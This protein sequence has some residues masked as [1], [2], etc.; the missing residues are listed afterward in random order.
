MKILGFEIPWPKK[1]A[2]PGPLLSSPSTS[3]GNHGWYPLIRES[4]TGAWQR[5]VTIERANVFQDSTI[6]RCVTLIASDV[7]KLRLKLVA[8]G[9]DGLWTETTNSAYSPLLR[10]PNGFQTRQQFIES[11]ICSKLTAG[12]FYALK[13]RDNRG[14]VTKLYPLDPHRVKPLVSDD[15][16]VFY[17]LKA[18]NI[19]GVD[20]VVIP[21][22]EIIHDRFNCL[23]HPL[24]G[25]SP[26]HAAG[27][28]ATAAQAIRG[29]SAAFFA[30]QSTPSGLLIAPGAISDETAQRLKDGW[31]ANFSGPSGMGK[32]A[33]LGDDLKYQQLAM[34][35]DA[36]QLVEQAQM[37]KEDIATAFGVPLHKIGGPL[38]NVGNIEVLEQAYYSQTIQVIIEGLESCLDEGLSLPS[39]LGVELDLDGLLRMDT[40]AQ[41][42]AL[43]DAVGAGFMS[44]NEARR[45]IELPAIKGGETPYLQQQ[46]YSLE[47]LAKRDAQADPFNPS[48]PSA[49]DPAKR[50][51]TTVKAISTVR[52]LKTIADGDARI[53]EGIAT[54]PV[55][56]RQGDCIVP[57]GITFAPTVKLLLH[58]DPRLPVGTVRFDRPTSSGVKFTATLPKVDE[59]GSV[60]D[61]VNEAWHSLKYG[62]ISSVSI[63][64]RP[65][66]D[67]MER[68]DTG[69]KYTAIE[70]LELSLVAVAANQEANVI[71][72]R[73]LEA[74]I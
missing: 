46:N 58:H 1:K 37:S 69:W 57:S 74:D 56:D 19:A 15:G 8:Q 27:L 47:A 40:A 22:S 50:A 43:K 20:D 51:R 66:D 3:G 38:P 64:F 32:L 67:G 65:L 25:V 16:S 14:V 11:W 52:A 39:Y 30:N 54:T 55:V 73:H 28:A 6:F 23:F 17:D 70:I 45:R 63:G 59:P 60:Q 12:N 21:A 53:I 42:S 24:V 35:A 61:R 49:P 2:L 7:S 33:V 29:N 62:L 26:I 36:A 41:V 34:A 44:P 31:Q 5:G 68:I 13:E 18:D 4:F 9:R 48:S 72:V 71:S 10:K